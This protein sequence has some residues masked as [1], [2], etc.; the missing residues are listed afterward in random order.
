MQT[1]SDSDKDWH[2]DELALKRACNKEHARRI[3]RELYGQDEIKR[4]ELPSTG[5][6]KRLVYARKAFPTSG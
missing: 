4:F 6:R 5:G 3:C 1:L 2:V